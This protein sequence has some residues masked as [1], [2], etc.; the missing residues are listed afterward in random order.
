MVQVAR[1]EPKATGAKRPPLDILA[2]ITAERDGYY[3]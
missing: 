3:A 2:L 1:S